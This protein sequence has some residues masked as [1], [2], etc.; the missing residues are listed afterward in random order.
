MRQETRCVRAQRQV[1]S[2]AMRNRLAAFGRGRKRTPD[3]AGDPTPA[4]TAAEA[5]YEPAQDGTI[6]LA[7]VALDLAGAGSADQTRLQLK[8]NVH[9]G[10][11]PRIIRGWELSAHIAGRYETGHE[12]DPNGPAGRRSAITGYDAGSPLTRERTKSLQFAFPG[13]SRQEFLDNLAG[14]ELTLRATDELG[15]R[16]STRLDLVALRQTDQ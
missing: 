3:T 5:W 12:V 1:K 14:A 7:I 10:D 6:T 8:V 4:A 15:A 11:P 2:H 13:M 16:W 9:H